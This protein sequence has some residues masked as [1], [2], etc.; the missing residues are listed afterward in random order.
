MARRLKYVSFS[1]VQHRILELKKLLSLTRRNVNHL[2]QSLI[3]ATFF[4]FIV[5]RDSQCHD[6]IVTIQTCPISSAMLFSS[7]KFARHFA[8]NTEDIYEE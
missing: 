4:I 2:W 5:P 1:E 3:D 8:G 7:Q 6:I